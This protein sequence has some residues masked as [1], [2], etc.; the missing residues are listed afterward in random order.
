MVSQFHS[1]SGHFTKERE[2]QREQHIL[3]VATNNHFQVFKIS[4]AYIFRSIAIHQSHLCL[5]ASSLPIEPEQ[6][7]SYCFQPGKNTSIYNLGPTAATFA[8]NTRVRSATRRAAETNKPNNN[9]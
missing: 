2:Q 5:L 4:F 1:T 6:S 7:E 3:A 9:K 8:W